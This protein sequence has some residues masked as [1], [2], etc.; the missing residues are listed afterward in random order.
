MT[1]TEQI[2]RITALENA[3]RELYAVA[4]S[5]QLLIEVLLVRHMSELSPEDRRGFID[6]MVEL[7]SNPRGVEPDAETTALLRKRLRNML[8][9]ANQRLAN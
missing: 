5:Q 6:R 8:E 9:T 1:E 3:W 2:A 7:G 4:A